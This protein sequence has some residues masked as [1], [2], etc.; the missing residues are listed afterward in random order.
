MEC[1]CD[2]FP[3]DFEKID[4]ETI[5]NLLNEGRTSIIAHLKFNEMKYSKQITYLNVY[6]EISMAFENGNI[7]QAYLFLS[8]DRLTNKHLLIE[9]ARRIICSSKQDC[10]C[11]NCLKIE[12]NSH[13]DVLVYP[14]ETETFNVESAA[15]IYSKIQ[16]N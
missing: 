15:D 9:V 1:G 14:K 11:G 6:K 4:V 12:A 10:V 8:P 2:Y 5:E 16:I 7:N 13:P 3:S